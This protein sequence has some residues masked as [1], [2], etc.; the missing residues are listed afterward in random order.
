M[1]TQHRTDRTH[2][3]N[4]TA[5]TSSFCHAK[6]KSYALHVENFKLDVLLRDARR[7]RLSLDFV[8]WDDI[9]YYWIIGFSVQ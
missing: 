9:V 5:V 4:V 2:L 1:I 7:L 6:P 8:T 3:E